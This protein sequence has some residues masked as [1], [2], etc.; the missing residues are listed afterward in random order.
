MSN[1]LMTFIDKL[2][3]SLEEK[4]YDVNEVKIFEEQ[5]IINFT[6]M[7]DM[8]GQMSFNPKALGIN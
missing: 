6:T 1:A 7:F 5:V 2:I 3:D 4:G 8:S